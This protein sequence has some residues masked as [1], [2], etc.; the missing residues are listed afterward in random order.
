MHK[1]EESITSLL[2]SAHQE[3]P[4]KRPH[5]NGKRLLRSKAIGDAKRSNDAGKEEPWYNE[6]SYLARNGQESVFLESTGKKEILRKVHVR[7]D[8]KTKEFL[9]YTKK[10]PVPYNQVFDHYGHLYTRP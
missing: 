3:G 10:G 8:E 7:L 6:P 9:Y 5:P 4:H 2:L 1:D